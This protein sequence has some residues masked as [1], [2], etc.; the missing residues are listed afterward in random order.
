[1]ALYGRAQLHDLGEAVRRLPAMLD[2]EPAGRRPRRPPGP[3]GRIVYRP[4]RFGLT[5]RFAPP[6]DRGGDCLRLI[7]VQKGGEGGKRASAA[8]P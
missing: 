4:G 1:M 3:A 2:R 7:E 6:T 8:T 5:P